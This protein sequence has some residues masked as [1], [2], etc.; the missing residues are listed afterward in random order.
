MKNNNLDFP[1]YKDNPRINI[2]DIV[3]LLSMP[4][5]FTIYT[6]L[7]FEIP[8]G[9]GPYLFFATQF[10]AFLYVA[11]G[12]VS[13]LIKK[14]KFKDYIRIIWTLILQYIV[15]IS[16][17]LTLEHVF[18][19]VSNDNAIFNMNMDVN[20]WFKIIF[21]LF[22]EELYKILIFLSVLTIMYKKTKNRKLSIIISKLISVL[23]FSFLHMTTYN[24]IIQILL[25]QG[26]ASLCCYYNYLKTKNILTS[27]LQHLLF[28]A[29]P[30]I[31]A[32]LNIV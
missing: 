7:S 11:H 17:A 4:I 32:M 6:F 22:G 31:I 26:L 8:F 18:N 10:I 23:C 27:Y 20:F 16:I 3:I 21:Q 2:K 28:D 13:L 29:I 9:L 5:F 24:N 14:P 30:F 15:A 12:K 25:V 1:F 19:I